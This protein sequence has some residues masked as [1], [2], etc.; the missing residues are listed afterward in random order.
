MVN[1]DLSAL[2]MNNGDVF[3]QAFDMDGRLVIKKQ[4]IGNGLELINIDRMAAGAYNFV[5]RQGE[6]IHQQKIIKID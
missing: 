3:I 5:I 4:I 6:Q 2:D 1:I